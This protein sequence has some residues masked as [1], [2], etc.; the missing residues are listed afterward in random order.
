MN[1]EPR[2]TI[3]LTENQIGILKFL[4]KDKLVSVMYGPNHDRADEAVADLKGVRAALEDMDEDFIEGPLLRLGWW[5]LAEP[6]F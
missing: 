6:I 5:E 2:Y 1:H 3:E 4:A